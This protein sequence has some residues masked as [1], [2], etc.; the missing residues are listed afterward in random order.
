VTL[1]N[2]TA[3]TTVYVGGKTV[4]AA[5]GY[6]LPNGTAVTTGN[7]LGASV[8]FAPAVGDIYAIATGG[9]A[10]LHVAYSYSD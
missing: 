4:T 1:T 9:A 7:I 8:T 3:S 5:N 10:V 6:G 2:V